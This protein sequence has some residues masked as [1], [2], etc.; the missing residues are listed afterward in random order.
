MFIATLRT[1][2]ICVMFRR[3]RVTLWLGSVGLL[4]AVVSLTAHA[5]PHRSVANNTN[6]PD[7]L[8]VSGPQPDRVQAAQAALGLC[9]EDQAAKSGQANLGVCELI[10]MDDVAITTANELLPSN[11]VVPLYLWRFQSQNATVYLA[12]TVHI[13]KETLYPLPRQF[14]EA[15]HATNNLVFEVDLSRYSDAEIQRSTLENAQLSG[16]FLRQSMPKDT[17][18][19]LVQA[20]MIY[21]LPIGQMQNFKPMLAFQQ[22]GVLGFMALGYNPVYGIDHYFGQLGQK[23]SENVLQLESL[24]L[25]LN[26]LFNQPMAVQVAVLEQALDDL[27][28]LEAATENL[29]GAYFNGD[30]NKMMAL[31][32]EQAGENPLT[33]AFN[34]QLIDQRNRNMARILK[35]YLQSSDSYLVLVGAAHLVGPQGIV[36]LL[37]RAGFKG[38]RIYSNQRIDGNKQ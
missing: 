7:K 24:E 11:E 12:G 37:E 35:R 34:Q 6:N 31:L 9:R 30:D 3:G 18:D 5:Q 25:Q 2:V 36:S 38:S 22:L 19:Q 27:D 15:Y 23:P 1:T 14:E 4:F 10:Q 33:I 29:I 26:L 16:Q 32:D 21:G 17:Y 8:Y 28:D 13:L 20:G